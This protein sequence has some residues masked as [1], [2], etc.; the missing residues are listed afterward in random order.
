MRKFQADILHLNIVNLFT[1]GFT[2]NGGTLEATIS[3]TP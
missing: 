2:I 3:G 1:F